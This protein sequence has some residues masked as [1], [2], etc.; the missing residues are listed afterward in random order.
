[1]L[2]QRK[3]EL[4]PALAK[5]GPRPNESSEQLSRSLP[6]LAERSPLRCRPAEATH[7]KLPLPLPEEGLSQLVVAKSP[8]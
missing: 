8:K 3:A 2:G 6:A 7:Q 4:L 5:T 1:M